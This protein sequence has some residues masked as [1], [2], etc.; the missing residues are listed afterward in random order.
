MITV[1]GHIAY[2]YIFNL[3]NSHYI[4]YFR[5][6]Y[7]GGGTNIAIGLASLGKKVQLYS[8]AGTDFKKYENYLKKF[9][10]NKRIIKSN[11]KC[12]RAYIFNI[13]KEQKTYFYWGASEEMENMKG[14]KSDILHI[15]PCHPKLAMRMAEK[16]KFFGFEPGQDLKKFNRRELKYIIE[17]ADIIFCNRHEAEIIKE[18]IKEF[19]KDKEMIITLGE[20]GS[21]IYREKKKI[22]S[23][24]V[25]CIDA[26]GA[27]DAFKAGFWYGWLEGY[28]IE[29][30]CKIGTTLASFVIEKFGAQNFPRY[31]DFV[32]R[33]EKNFGKL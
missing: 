26:T 10:L 33:Y 9:E 20:K 12:A 32:E 15:S 18:I 2:D 8:V 31:E 29:K 27:G 17:K 6:C 16:S 7:G 4:T 30:C 21:M 13:G 25:K 1:V 14:I 28:D 22:P 24:K 3:D 11:K 5:K 19:I 23:I